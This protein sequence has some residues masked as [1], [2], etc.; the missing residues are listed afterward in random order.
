VAA[1]RAGLADSGAV[2]ARHVDAARSP[3]DL[4]RTAQLSGLTGG[5][6]W[7]VAAFAGDGA[8]AGVLL[9]V[10][11]LLLTV[12]LAGLGL[13]LVKSDVV[14][15]RVFVG[16]ALPTLVWGVVALVRGSAVSAS[17]VDVVFGGGIALLS[18]T[19][20]LRRREPRRTTL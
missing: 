18:A 5:V 1:T 16:L 6:L 2:M 10:G 15:L 4:R 13:L 7:V 19:Q 12:A 20:L 14:P 9:W 11:G 8:A 17:V 3:L